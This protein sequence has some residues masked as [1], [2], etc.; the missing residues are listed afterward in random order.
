MHTPNSQLLRRALQ[1]NGIFS[2]L[3]GLAMIF[4]SNQFA[5]LLGL[6]QT[7]PLLGIGI[8]LVLYAAGLLWNARR[9][10]INLKEAQLAVIMDFA[11]VAGSAIVIFTGML[12][13]TGNWIV[14]LVADVVLL[15]GVLQWLGIRKL[16]RASASS[17]A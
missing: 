17:L 12:S 2:G 9:A 1:V 16:Q 15:F 14:A 10:N 4:A 8:A 7:G 6:G 13:A 11:W 5:L 3:S